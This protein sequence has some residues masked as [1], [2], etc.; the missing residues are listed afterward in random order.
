MFPS[1]LSDR[2][3]H[4]CHRSLDIC[5]DIVRGRSDRNLKSSHKDST[6]WFPVEM[7]EE[8]V[9][10]RC[11]EC[12]MF[13]KHISRKSTKFCCKICGE[14]QSIIR[15]YGNGN[16]PECRRTVQRLNSK[17]AEADSDEV[18]EELEKY[19]DELH[20]D[21]LRKNGYNLRGDNDDE[22]DFNLDEAD[23]NG[24]GDGVHNHHESKN[25]NDT[26]DEGF[27]EEYNNGCNGSRLKSTE[28]MIQRYSPDETDAVNSNRSD[29][30]DDNG[31]SSA[32]NCG[33]TPEITKNSD[34]SPRAK[35]SKYSIF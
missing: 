23:F 4:C 31:F 14:K 13:Q 26:P 27:E 12:R 33:P 10:L 16:G 8:F 15:C 1:F 3:G 6:P 29:F 18:E 21:V 34:Q 22:T 7:P 19:S 20:E 17:C 35:R 32:A 25:N 28:G 30:Q 2:S 9:V 24:A 11:K 5:D